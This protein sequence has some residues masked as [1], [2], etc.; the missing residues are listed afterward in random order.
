[1]NHEERTKILQQAFYRLGYN[2]DSAWTP[3]RGSARHPDSCN[4]SFLFFKG[5][6]AYT[7]NFQM[8]R[9]YV[10]DTEDIVYLRINVPGI[11]YGLGKNPLQLDPADPEFKQKVEDFC[12]LLEVSKRAVK[13]MHT[14][15]SQVSSMSRTREKIVCQTCNG[16]KEM[17]PRPDGSQYPSYMRECKVCRGKGCRIKISYVGYEEYKEGENDKHLIAGLTDSAAMDQIAELKETPGVYATVMG[18]V[19]KTFRNL[20]EKEWLSIKA[21]RVLDREAQEAAKKKEEEENK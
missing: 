18:I 19:R 3:D 10:H 1:M 14:L 5:H 13:E 12:K 15:Q 8:F 11:E 17:P 16:T 4:T 21:Q 9:G 6:M 7:N 20:S 2:D